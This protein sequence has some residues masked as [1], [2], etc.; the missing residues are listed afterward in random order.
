[1][2]YFSDLSIIEVEETGRDNSYPSPETQLRWKL[3]DLIHDYLSLGG[4]LTEVESIFKASTANMS[5]TDN[6]ILY[7]A[8]SSYSASIIMRCIEKAWAKLPAHKRTIYEQKKFFMMQNDYLDYLILHGE[9]T[10]N[11]IEK[12]A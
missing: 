11:R 9:Q 1:M 2:S 3:E 5:S 10:Q 8:N 6:E 12:A 7:S 4:N